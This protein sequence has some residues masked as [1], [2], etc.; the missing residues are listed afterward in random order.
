MP[1]W[2]LTRRK[3]LNRTCDIRNDNNVLSINGRTCLHTID[4]ILSRYLC[5]CVEKKILVFIST[6]C[7]LEVSQKYKNKMWIHQWIHANMNKHNIRGTDTT[8]IFTAHF[9]LTP[10]VFYL[11]GKTGLSSTCVRF[12]FSCLEICACISKANYPLCSSPFSTTTCNVAGI[13]PLEYTDHITEI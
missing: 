11:H 8:R 4:C 7:L 9:V 10:C 1:T 3:I 13:T 12:K 2:T 5:L 6:T